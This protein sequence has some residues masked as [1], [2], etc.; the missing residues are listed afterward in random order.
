MQKR[1]GW[2]LLLMGGMLAVA[3]GCSMGNK[4]TVTDER[5]A[6]F[7]WQKE[8]VEKDSSALF[9]TAR[10][11]NLCVLYQHFSKELSE[12]QIASFVQAGKEEKIQI[13]LLDGD[14]AWGRESDG[15][16]MKEAVRRTY[17]YN[18]RN[19]NAALKGVIL[20][21][22][23]YLLEEWETDQEHLMEGYVSGVRESYKLAKANRLDFALCIP[24][25]YDTWGQEG[26]LEELVQCCDTLV[27]MNYQ[28]GSEE[29]Q[30]RTEAE[31]AEKYGKE[32]VNVY[33]LQ[34]AGTHGITHRNTYYEA[35]LEAL[36]E[37]FS[38]LEKR[39]P[40]LQLY[41]GLHDYEALQE[42]LKH[43]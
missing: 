31:L 40:G 33:E 5:N 6:L 15:G 11:Q 37:N 18:E 14:P 43:E 23:P 29:E 27:V 7:S 41:Y 36:H 16:S 25:F 21:V 2:I 35:G 30:I 22:E 38:E 24:C 34:Q 12:E 42:V 28:R 19:P 13:Y 32:L 1:F 8:V 10:E 39:Y 17:G 9:L 4:K 3:G 20:D 26:V